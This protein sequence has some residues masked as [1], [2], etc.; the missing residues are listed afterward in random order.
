MSSNDAEQ[1][2]GEL[3]EGLILEELQGLQ[4]KVQKVTH[5]EVSLEGEKKTGDNLFPS[6]NKDN[7]SNFT[8]VRH[9]CRK[10]TQLLETIGSLQFVLSVC[11]TTCRLMMQN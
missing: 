11:N 1:L 3:N 5:E 9:L 6:E 10:N 2:V 7:F 4:L 8:K